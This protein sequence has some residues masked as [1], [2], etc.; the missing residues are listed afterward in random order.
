M[1]SKG[2]TIV[3]TAIILPI[4]LIL[5]LGIFEFGR[6]MYIKN[7]LNNAARAGARAAVVLP[8][9][10]ATSRPTGLSPKAGE[11]LNTACSFNNENKSVYEIVCGSLTSGIPRGETT[12][13]ISAFTSYSTA[14]TA[15]TTGD[16]ITV[17]VTWA[18]FQT[19]V[20]KIIPLGNGLSGEASMRYE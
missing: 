17:S 6:A 8:T 16:R 7:T 1:N 10:D 4:L 19:V 14:T 9:Y 11:P 3:E 15:P 18:N 5:V 13:S 2:Q 12:V 20:S